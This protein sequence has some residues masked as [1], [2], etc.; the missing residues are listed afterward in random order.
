MSDS[1]LLLTKKLKDEE[2][3]MK[4]L[5]DNREIRIIYMNGDVIILN[6]TVNIFKDTIED[7]Y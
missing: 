4:V 6:A 3:E 5:N 7:L 2:F 1:Q